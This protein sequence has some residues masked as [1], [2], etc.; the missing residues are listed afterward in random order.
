L[1]CN[2]R[3][4]PEE[5]KCRHKPIQLFADPAYGLEKTIPD[6]LIWFNKLFHM[7][8]NSLNPNSV[9]ILKGL[10]VA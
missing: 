5:L 1:V 2:L 4:G 3:I 6:N 8:K 10:R 9:F 7:P